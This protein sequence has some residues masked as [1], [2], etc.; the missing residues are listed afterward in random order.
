MLVSSAQ[1]IRQWAETCSRWWWAEMAAATRRWTAADWP[2]DSSGTMRCANATTTSNKTTAT[3]AQPDDWAWF[4][5]TNKT[6]TLYDYIRRRT[7]VVFVWGRLEFAKKTF[8]ESLESARRALTWVTLASCKLRVLL[9]RRFY[10]L[11]FKP[12]RNTF[13][14]CSYYLSNIILVIVSIILI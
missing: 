6:T 14:R 2:L 10:L 13:L 3:F 1:W 12:V 11:V 5:R 9:F 4:E 8:Y 7:F